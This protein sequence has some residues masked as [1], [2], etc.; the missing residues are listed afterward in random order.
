M[1]QRIQ[2][3]Y[4][5]AA[6]VV[7]VLIFNFPLWQ[8]EGNTNTHLPKITVQA[9]HTSIVSGMDTLE[10]T[11]PEIIIINSLIILLA[12]ADLFLFRKRKLQLTISRVLILLT[13]ILIA[14]LFFNIHIGNERFQSIEHSSFYML[15][16]YLPFISIILFFLAGRAIN[17]DEKLVRSADRLR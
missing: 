14:T 11:H 1:I 6:I 17:A 7:Q 15:S 16:V 13:C 4:L 2:S 9:N 10:I 8:G 3:I 12:I 5:L